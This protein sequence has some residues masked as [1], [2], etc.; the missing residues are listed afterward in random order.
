[1]RKN[2]FF[3]YQSLYQEK[4]A[5]I[6]PLHSWLNNGLE[7]QVENAI[8]HHNNG[9]FDRW[10]K[11][12]QQLPSLDDLSGYELSDTVRIGDA[13]DLSAETSERLANNLQLLHPW[14]KGP[15]SF[16]GCH[17]D[18][19]WRSDWKWQRVAPHI[20]NLRNRRVLDVGAGNGYFGWRMLEAGAD[21]VL[22]VEPFLA[23][24]Y[25]HLAARKYLSRLD[26]YLLPFGI[27]DVPEKLGVFDTVFSMGVL[28]HRKSPI[29]HLLDL[30]HQLVKGG[31]LV[32]ETLVVEG[33]INTALVPQGRYAKMRNVWFLPSVLMLE[34]W[35]KKVGYRDVQLVDLNFTSTE[36][37]R[38]TE[39][40]K[41]ESL[42]DYLHPFDKT[43][44]VEGHP[45]P[46][47]AT[48][49]AKN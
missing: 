2:I 35:L 29:D 8:L 9:H 13:S 40:M 33:D 38:S 14:R 17:I 47:R 39:W 18:T 6:E 20:S 31:E 23:F 30:R 15:F 27:E 28:Y 42:P 4:I 24:V 41:F 44:T 32:L 48:I 25:Q 19:E 21:F 36:E 12:F 49:I 37:Q 10:E 16:F 22:G 26:N 5:G 43:K 45:A 34:N 11:C 7:Q 3:D 46:L 1:M